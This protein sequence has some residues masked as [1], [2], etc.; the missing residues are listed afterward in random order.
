MV[1]VKLWSLT[2]LTTVVIDTYMIVHVMGRHNLSEN[3]THRSIG[4]Y[5]NAVCLLPVAELYHHLIALYSLS[6]F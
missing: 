5:G 4:N 6:E 1:S 2:S 3:P